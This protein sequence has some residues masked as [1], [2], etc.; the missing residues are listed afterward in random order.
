[1]RVARLSLLAGTVL[2][3]WA[4]VVAAQT[5]TVND[6][7]LQRMW[8]AGMEESRA[9]GLAQVLLDS[10]GPRLTG[11]PQSKAAQDW[12]VGLYQSWGIDARNEQYGT[13]MSW[14]RGTSHIDLVEPRVR[15]LEGTML[16]WSPGTKRKRA[17]VV[18]P[19][20]AA[21]SV[22]FA[23][24]LPQVKGKYVLLSFP[25]PTCR[26]NDN[27]EENAAGDSFERMSAEREAASEAWEA[28]LE[29]SG[30]SQSALAGRLEA[31]G[32][33]GVV[34]GG[35]A[36]GWGVHRVFSARTEKVPALVLSCE[37]YGLVFR[38]AENG[39]GPVLEVE[40]EADFHGQV[41]VFNT[42]AEI[43]GSEKPDEY[44]LLSAHF[45]SWDGGS[46]ATDNGTG[47]ITIMEAMRIIRE[48]YPNPKRT[49]IAGHWNA[50]EQGLI[51]SRAFAADH[52]EVSEGLQALFNQDNGTG[53]IVRISMQGLMEA[54]EYFSRWLA[55]VPGEIAQQ[56]EVTVPGTPG[57]GGSDYASFVCS[58]A[59]S[60]FL[61]AHNWSYFPYTWHTN[62][63]TFDKIVED[64]LKNN[65]TLFAMLAYLA[66]EDPE[67]M[68]RDQRV[69]PVSGRT[70][71][72]MTWPECRLPMRS[73]E[74]YRNR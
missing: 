43:R 16:A 8:T 9:L 57:G 67:L 7:V 44:V 41:P 70:G 24:W 19:P 38:L 30:L 14:E 26:P 50:E 54:G 61:F 29:A 51:G 52:P 23:A 21:D 46:G 6:P 35:R 1:M 66:S 49:I 39:Q 36:L 47:T 71:E 74:E 37:D 11:T 4:P 60:F 45:D 20:E 25:E 58:G 59:P 53:R 64:D 55:R 3:A 68:P 34:T 48:A 42:I 31:A 62:R 28:R 40:A 33:A 63:D 2:L 18:I 32:A 27:W 22:A 73:W 56:I 17:A 69:L 5:F 15:T 10:L 12:V 65:A 72:Q 13:W